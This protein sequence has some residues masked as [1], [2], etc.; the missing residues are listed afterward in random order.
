MKYIIPYLSIFYLFSISSLYSQDSSKVSSLK[1]NFA[2]QF[3]VN[4]FYLQQFQGSNLSCKYHVSHN[5]AWRL[6]VGISASADLSNKF[7]NVALTKNEYQ[8]INLAIQY[9]RYVKTVDDISLYL[10][11]GPNYTRY[12][13]KYDNWQ[14]RNNSWSLGISGIVGMEW[15]FNSSMSMSG[16]Y[17]I[18]LSYNNSKS[19]DSD[20]NT[21]DS[22]TINV[23]SGNQFKIG[24]SVYL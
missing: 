16:E 11:S 18:L 6:G 19:V 24:L 20:G 15:F 5:S 4:G 17:G 13:R 9:I 14:D 21:S 8:S 12:Y 23:G 2:L 1:D 22:Q 7:N 10:G 3:Q